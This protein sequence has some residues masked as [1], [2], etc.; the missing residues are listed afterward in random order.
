MRRRLRP[1]A[2]TACRTGSSSDRSA[3]GSRRPTRAAPTPTRIRDELL[4][5]VQLAADSLTANRGRHAGYFL[6]RRFIRRVRTFG[7]H[8]ATMDVTQ[9]GARPPR[10]DRPGPRDAR[11]DRRCRARSG[12]CA[13][14]S[15]WRA[16]SRRRRR[17]MPAGRRLLWVFD[18]IA[19]ARHKF[20]ERAIGSYI[21]AGAEGADDLLAVLLLARWAD[22]TDKRTGE[23]PARCRAAPGIDRG[24]G[25]RRRAA[26]RA[27]QGARVSPASRGARQ[28]ADRRDRV[29][30]HQQAGGL[31]G[32]PVGAAG[33]AASAAGGRPR[34]GARA[35]HLLRPRRYPGAR[36]RT[37]REFGRG[38]ADRRHPR[39][40]APDRAG[41]GGE[42]E[43]RPSAHRD[44]HTRADIRRGGARDGARGLAHAPAPEFLAAMRTVA[45]KSFDAYRGLMFDGA[46]FAE[47]LPGGHTARRDRAHAHRLAARRTR[48]AARV[49]RRC[50]PYPGCS[51]GRRAGTCSLGGSGSAAASRRRSRRTARTSSARC[52]RS[53]LFSR[54]SSMTWNPCWREPICEIAAHYDALAE[55]GPH[56]VRRSHPPGIR[57]DGETRSARSGA[58]RRLL[59]SDPTLQRRS[60]CAIP[61]SIPCI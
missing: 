57:A 38:G 23:M 52:W 26:A 1:R 14:A 10:G 49:S 40:A 9:I 47:Y 53:G 35:D 37:D 19:H 17:S 41:R 27:A 32:V 6:V 31:C 24:A 46:R 8:I 16:I 21:V 28:S 13:C 43:L 59:E 22:T 61:T 54:I 42:P 55:R 11:M 33:R 30:G 25:E 58:R 45:S 36:R 56:R 20:G 34:Y 4:A 3:S 51:P 5:D 48:D 12:W 29:F 39:R 2:T 7:F 60:R 18:T 50:A 44:A 15:S